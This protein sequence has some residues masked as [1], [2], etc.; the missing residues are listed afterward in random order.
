MTSHAGAVSVLG[1]GRGQLT[2]GTSWVHRDGSSS[3]WDLDRMDLVFKPK[4][5]E[6]NIWWTMGGGH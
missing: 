4:L 3:S 2:A 5:K 1:E 6:L